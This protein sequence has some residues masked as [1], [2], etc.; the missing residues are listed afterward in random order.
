MIINKLPQEIINN[1]LEYQGYHK[2]RNGKYMKQIQINDPKY[3]NLKNIHKNIKISKGWGVECE[4]VK[5]ITSK[6]YRFIITIITYPSY[7]EWNMQIIP[8][9]VMTHEDLTNEIIYQNKIQKHQPI[10]TKCISHN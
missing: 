10:I 4:F 6:T 1:I 5:Y 9:Y 7:V 3:S 8:I 2:E